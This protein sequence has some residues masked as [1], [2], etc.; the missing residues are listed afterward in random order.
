M[1]VLN[2][3]DDSLALKKS[4]LKFLSSEMKLP[5]SFTE[6]LNIVRAFT[7]AKLHEGWSTIYAEFEDNITADMIQQHAVNLRP[8]KSL[9]L[10]VPRSLYPRFWAVNEIAHSCRNG[11]TKHKTRVKYGVSDFVLIIKPRDSRGPWTYAPLDAFPALKLSP[12]TDNLDTTPESRPR[13]PSKRGRSPEDQTLDDRSSKTRKDESSPTVSKEPADPR[14]TLPAVKQPDALSSQDQILNRQPKSIDRGS[15]LP[16][17]CL[18]PKAKKNQNFTF[19]AT[20][21]A[22]SVC[23][24]DQSL[25]LK[26]PT[27]NQ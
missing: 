26:A 11:S 14:I 3:G 15:F 2:I 18:S 8:G 4:V 24:E 6:S 21:S 13:L 27:K 10:Y 20:P 23:D 12:F 9:S 1:S 7:P 25:N 5:Q 17:A 16:V 19:S 22:L